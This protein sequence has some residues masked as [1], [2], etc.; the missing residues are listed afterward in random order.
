M[1]NCMNI[2]SHPRGEG[3]KSPSNEKYGEGIIFFR[4][5]ISPYEERIRRDVERKNRDAS[6]SLLGHPKTNS[7]M[8][9]KKSGFCFVLRPFF[10][11]FAAKFK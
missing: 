7:D 2:F 4:E 3:R 8:L 5:G 9:A 10:A 1:K 6:H 11:T